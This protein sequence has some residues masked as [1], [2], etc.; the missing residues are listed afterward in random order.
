MKEYLKEQ[1]AKIQQVQF[2]LLESGNIHIEVCTGS[3][4]TIFYVIYCHVYK[5]GE[6][7][8]SARFEMSEY[9]SIEKNDAQMT[10]FVNYISPY[11][12]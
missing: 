8:D 11:L 6:M 10:E 1:F 4:D 3:I 2:S 12:T 9:A 5:N 7:A